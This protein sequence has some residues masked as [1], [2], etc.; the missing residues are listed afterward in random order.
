MY[1]KI[2]CCCHKFINILQAGPKL[3]ERFFRW[4]GFVLHRYKWIFLIV[5]VVFTLLSS[6]GFYFME[7]LTKND[8]EYVL[9]PFGSQSEYEKA[10]IN[11]QFPLKQNNYIPGKFFQV[12]NWIDVAVKARDHGNLLRPE[13][14]DA[15]NE[16]NDYLMFKFTVRTYDN[17]FNLTYQDLC[18]SWDD[19]CFENTQV[20][21]M[22]DFKLLDQYEVPVTFPITRKGDV[23][24]YLAS[25]Y[26]G[27]KT[28]DDVGRFNVVTAV[29]L[30][31]HLIQEPHEIYM[32]AVQFRY[33]FQDFIVNYKSPYLEVGVYHADTV[34]QGLREVA[35]AFIPQY[36]IMCMILSGFSGRFYL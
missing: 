35:D 34:N 24:V 5:P 20:Q 22:K 21:L 25:V 28:I 31:Y 23:P 11:E 19:N 2:F 27:V 9:C 18:L 14:I 17:K 13:Y 32:Y 12:K 4:Y 30:S 8:T 36:I 15:L 16:F 29:R 7:N 6:T 10:V 1:D 3:L 26:G 33:A